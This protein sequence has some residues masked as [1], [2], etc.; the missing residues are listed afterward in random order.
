MLARNQIV[1]PREAWHRLEASGPSFKMRPVGNV[2]PAFGHEDHAAPATN[3]RDRAIIADEESLILYCYKRQR[4][5]GARAKLSDRLG[6]RGAKPR[7][8][9]DLGDVGDVVGLPGQP[10]ARSCP[11]NARSGA[12]SSPESRSI[13][14]SLAGPFPS[15]ALGPS[16]RLRGR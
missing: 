4:C 10:F 16:A 8:M 13:V 6:V 5:L 12:P 1:G 15:L 11:R 14:E 9:A 2:E 7:R 3:I